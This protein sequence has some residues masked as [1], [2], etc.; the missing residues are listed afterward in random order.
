MR[1]IVARGQEYTD[2]SGRLIIVD[3]VRVRYFDGKDQEVVMF[4]QWLTATGLCARWLTTE[5]FMKS[6][7]IKG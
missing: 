5:D 1:P 6:F 2:R 7:T 3:D 4:R